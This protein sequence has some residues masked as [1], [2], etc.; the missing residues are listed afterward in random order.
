M[1]WDLKR[2]LAILF[3]ESLFL[4]IFTA[5]FFTVVYMIAMNPSKM[6]TYLGRWIT[7]TLL[8]A[9]V[10]LCIVGFVKLDAPFQSPSEAYQTGAFFTGFLEGYNTMDALASLAFGIVILNSIQK[11]GIS[12]RKQLTKYTLRAGIVAGILLSMVYISLGI[13]GAKM[14]AVGTY[15]N[16]TDVLTTTATTLFG[17]SGKVLIGVIFTLA[18]LASVTGLTTACGQYFSELIPKASY[19]TCVIIVTLIGFL[20]A[21]LGLEQILKISVPFLVM[22]YPL[23]IV[24]IVLTFFSKNSKNQ[25]IVYQS[26]LLF[27]GVFAVIDGLSAFGLKLGAIQTFSA[28]LPF[29]AYGLEWITPALVGIFF[30]FILSQTRRK[31]EV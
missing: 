8:I 16:G 15:A 13:I 5:I 19:K 7:P 20:F 1:K 27:T 6:E 14:S 17:T 2:I 12:D 4:F 3:N 29:A 25:N 21:N 26:A 23:T 28:S 30:G 9:M 10:I 31:V 24:L 22:A 11:R 18:C